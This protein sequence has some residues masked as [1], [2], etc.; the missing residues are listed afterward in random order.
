[1]A[2]LKQISF[3]IQVLMEMQNFNC[4]N[5]IFSTFVVQSIFQLFPK[6]RY[7][8]HPENP[9]IEQDSITTR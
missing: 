3:Y 1:M 8:L 2:I 9:I 6:K 7:M 4:F 5:A